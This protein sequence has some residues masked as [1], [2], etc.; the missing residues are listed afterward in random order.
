MIYPDDCLPTQQKAKGRPLSHTRWPLMSKEPMHGDL[1]P[2]RLSPWYRYA[3]ERLLSEQLW[4]TAIVPSVELFR[5]V[6]PCL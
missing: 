2:C 1:V 4:M 5:A 3:V 6:K